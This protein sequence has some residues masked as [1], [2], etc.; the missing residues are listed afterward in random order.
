M[1]QL[2]YVHGNDDSR[3][4]ANNSHIA[5]FSVGEKMMHIRKKRS[6][7]NSKFVINFGNYPIFNVKRL[8]LSISVIS[9]L[10]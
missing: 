4:D 7:L 2:F 6:I 9:F 5:K 1:K 10:F 3:R 8:L